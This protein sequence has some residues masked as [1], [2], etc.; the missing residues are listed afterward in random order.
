MEKGLDI[1]AKHTWAEDFALT[2]MMQSQVW[3][4]VK[5][6]ISVNPRSNHK[7]S[8][9][10]DAIKQ[11][12]EIFTLVIWMLSEIWRDENDWN[13]HNEKM[14]R[15]QGLFTNVSFV[16]CFIQSYNSIEKQM[17]GY[18]SK[19]LDPLILLIEKKNKLS[20]W[21]GYFYDWPTLVIWFTG[22]SMF[23]PRL[24]S[25]VDQTLVYCYSLSHI[26]IQS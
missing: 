25:V 17:K 8:V 26:G 19:L 10:F 6:C 11:N 20:P 7:V 2:F 14:A 23:L 24:E 9:I 21:I 16:L 15:H 22:N 18:T 5:I 1:V 3:D 4:V 13:N 12:E